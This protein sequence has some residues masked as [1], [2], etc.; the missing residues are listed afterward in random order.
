[1]ELASFFRF[2]GGS[3]KE[4]DKLVELFSNRTELK[5]EYA[6]LRDE[7]YELE[8]ELKRQQGE[9]L[10][11]KQKLEYLEG[12]LT[13]RNTAAST[14]AFYQLRGVWRGCARRLVKLSESMAKVISHRRQEKAIAEWKRD[15]EKQVAAIDQRLVDEKAHI[16]DLKNRVRTTLETIR[17]KE[18]AWHFF[19]RRRLQKE[20]DTLSRTLKQ[21]LIDHNTTLERKKTLARAK[22]PEI[23]ALT[24]DDRRSINLNVIA[25][26]QFMCG[27]FTEYKL[28]D[29]CHAAMSKQLG[30]IDYGDEQACEQIRQNARLALEALMKL[31]GTP[32]F[33]A[34][35]R[36]QAKH[37]A[38]FAT[39]P[40]EG[41]AVPE[42]FAV[43]TEEKGLV[44]KLV[45]SE[46]FASPAAVMSADYWSL[47][48]A[49]LS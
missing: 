3:R 7:R 26:A 43:D 22:P 40:D 45:V 42:P 15:H 31:D 21:Q 36:R 41:S 47:S 13:D 14:V 1:M 27:H 16:I 37:L 10:R 33:I 48:D 8:G 44:D 12:Q 38:G 4:S 17:T 25:M 39:Y 34:H 5:K 28:S 19:T 11:L 35:V 49:L 23:E 32:E 30:A 2:G 20:A 18:K 9:T 24:V 46:Y 6:R 29:A